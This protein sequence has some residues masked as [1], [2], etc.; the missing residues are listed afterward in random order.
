MQGEGR[1]LAICLGYGYA[2]YR[3]GTAVPRGEANV[4][5]VVLCSPSQAASVLLVYR[6]PLQAAQR[7]RSLGLDGMRSHSRSVPSPT[8][9]GP[10]VVPWLL[11]RTGRMMAPRDL[12]GWGRHC[13]GSGV[14]AGEVRQAAVRATKRIH[15]RPGG[16]CL[17]WHAVHMSIVQLALLPVSHDENLFGNV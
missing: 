4:P 10:E 3:E 2:R 1:E 17:R 16:L 15:P 7:T 11:M 8:A 6:T 14:G 13:S 12:R 9:R 5:C